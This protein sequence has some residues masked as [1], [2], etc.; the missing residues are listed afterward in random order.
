MLGCRLAQVRMRM[1]M[2]SLRRVLIG[3]LLHP[4]TQHYGNAV[5]KMN[6]ET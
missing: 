4:G 6:S 5:L 2:R 3:L 1:Q